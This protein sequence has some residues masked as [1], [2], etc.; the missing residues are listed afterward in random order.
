MSDFV[1]T[2]EYKRFQEFC[3]ACRKE[4]YIGLC[5]GPAGVGKSLSAEYFAKWSHISKDIGIRLPY[6]LRNKPSINMKNLSTIVYTPEIHNGPTQIKKDIK[7]IIQSF[8]FLKE[9]SIYGNNEVP[10]EARFK[11]YVDLIIIDEADRLR[12]S[13]IEQIRDIYDKENITVILIGM[14]G[15]EKNLIRFPQL[16]SRIGFS[17]NFQPLSQEEIVFIIQKQLQKL[18][19]N[20]NP[21][22]FTDKEAISAVVRVTKGNFRLIN[23]LL[24][25]VVRIMKINS[26]SSISSEVVEA[27]RECLVIGNV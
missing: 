24:K 18:H 14:P 6:I 4:K 2:K 20:I 10:Y 7:E 25:Q 16:Y 27:A 8:N 11:S 17:H 21:D 23:R 3:N 15:I 1:I 19:L 26:L 13:A 12:S 5:Y 22:D 9:K